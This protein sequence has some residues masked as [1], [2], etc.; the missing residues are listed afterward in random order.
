MARWM[1]EYLGIL[2]TAPIFIAVIPFPADYPN[3]V[4]G[5][6]MALSGAPDWYVNAVFTVL[7]ATYGLQI[8]RGVRLPPIP[9]P[10]Q[11]TLPSP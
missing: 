9:W 7:A 3:P 8:I 6:M 11:S 2:V 4:R 1:E 10:R 5:A